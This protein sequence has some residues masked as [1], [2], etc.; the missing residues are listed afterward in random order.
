MEYSQVVQMEKE[1]YECA[2]MA[3]QEQG[4]IFVDV[5]DVFAKT[6]SS[7]QLYNEKDLHINMTASLLI[8]QEQFRRIVGSGIL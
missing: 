5:L 8:A 7:I 3:V 2:R 1:L 4:W 6:N